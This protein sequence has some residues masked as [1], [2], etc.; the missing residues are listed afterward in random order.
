VGRNPKH[1][2]PQMRLHKGSGHARVRINGVEH[3]LGPFGSREAVS[4]YDRLI[5]HY[6]AARG[7]RPDGGDRDESTPPGAVPEP[8]AAP[9]PAVV[10]PQPASQQPVAEPK[11]EAAPAEITVA[12]M[13]VTYLDYAK[14]HYI[15]PDGRL[16]SSYHGMLQAVHALTPFQRIPAALFGPRCLREIMDRMAHEKGRNGRPRPRVTINRLVKRVRGIFKWAVSMELIPAQT[17]HA[18]M[19]VEGLRRGRSQAP[20]LPPVRPVSDEVVKQTL[21]HLPQVVADLVWFIRLTGCRPGE[22]CLLRP[23]DVDMSGAVWKWTLRS[24]KNSWRDHE[25]VVMIGPRGQSLLHPYIERLRSRPDGFCFSPRVSE[26]HRGRERR[27]SRQ[28]PMTPSQSTRKAKSLRARKRPPRD[29]YTDDTLNRC[30]RRACET[31]DL[32]RWTPMQLRHTAGTEARHAG[33][34][35]DAAQVRLGHRHANITEVYAEIAHEKAAE[36]AL[37]LG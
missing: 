14:T 15:L 29:H 23:I 30:I 2:L 21:P 4:A 3:W 13:C 9:S 10:A 7:A 5:A 28:S 24:H 12:E 17:W 18:L 8:E 26:Q 11:E 31:A 16:S 20:E 35:L 34:G 33:G 25:R 22:A 27:K 1:L 19:A 36:L 32:P 6:L 37:K